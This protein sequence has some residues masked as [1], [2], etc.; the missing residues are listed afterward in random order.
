MVLPAAAILMRPALPDTKPSTSYLLSPD[1]K[2]SAASTDAAGFLPVSFSPASPG[3]RGVYHI[4]PTVQVE[5]LHM[6]GGV[7]APAQGLAHVPHLDVELWVQGIQNTG[8]ANAGVSC[9]GRQLP[10]DQGF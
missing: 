10:S 2:K 9:K 7:A 6:P 8:F 4:R 5:Q 1:C 3:A